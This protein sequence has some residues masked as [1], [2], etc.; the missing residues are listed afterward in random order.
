MPAVKGK[1]PGPVGVLSDLSKV[2]PPGVE[3]PWRGERV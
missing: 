3:V 2:F 1:I